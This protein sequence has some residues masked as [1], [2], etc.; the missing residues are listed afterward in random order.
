MAS[1]RSIWQRSET[2]VFLPVNFVVSAR[3]LNS[4]ME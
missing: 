3:E 4:R 1:R 2:A